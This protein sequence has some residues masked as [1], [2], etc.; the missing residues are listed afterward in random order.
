M[1][2]SNAPTTCCSTSLF[3]LSLILKPT[4]F[5]EQGVLSSGCTSADTTCSRPHTPHGECQDVIMSKD[6][7][8]TLPRLTYSVLKGSPTKRGL[9]FSALECCHSSSCM[10]GLC[11]RISW[12]TD[13]RVNKFGHD[14]PG[15]RESRILCWQTKALP[16]QKLISMP[17]VISPVVYPT[18]NHIHHVS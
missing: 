11:Q 8:Q 1:W 15:F 16:D 6:S 7:Y 18:C 12:S 14:P 10:I 5:L 2:L 3:Q 17:H 13:N 9:S 4:N